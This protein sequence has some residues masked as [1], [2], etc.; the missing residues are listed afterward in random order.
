MKWISKYIL[1]G[2]FNL[3]LASIAF[4]DANTPHKSKKHRLQKES[5]PAPTTPA[6]TTGPITGN[7]DITSNY[8]FRGIS[9]SN[10][11]PAFQGGL[12]YTMPNGC[13]ANMWG[14]S[15]NLADNVGGTATLEIDGILGVTNKVG[16]N[17]S[18]D[19]NWDRY[20]YP[21]AV[22]TYDEFNA[23]LIYYFVVF[24]LGYS[25]NVYDVHKPGT[26]LNLGINYNIPPKY[27]FNL[28]N[29]NLSGGVGHYNLPRSA[30]LYSYWDYNVQLSKTYGS[31]V[32]A[33]QWTDTTNA[34]MEPLDGPHV[35]GT[36]T[37]NF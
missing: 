30:G 3:S 14:T 21:K 32:L 12:T 27:F 24:Q 7:F 1:V 19:I 34:H 31:Y 5:A 15:L 33:I 4:A 26:Y 23:K 10:N 13:Y 20:F 16:D 18:Y 22:L 6:A 8:M 9:N 25:T 36:I 2:I 17:F 28:E 35:I 11:L 37:V 29:V